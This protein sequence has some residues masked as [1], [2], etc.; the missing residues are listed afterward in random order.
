MIN[1]IYSWAW[2]SWLFY[3][4]SHHA[5]IKMSSRALISSETQD[6]LL[7]SPFV[8]RIQFLAV[9]EF[10]VSAPRSDPHSLP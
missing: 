5:E 9:V 1:M 8:A 10:R 4:G 6:H 2:V 7:N 3:S